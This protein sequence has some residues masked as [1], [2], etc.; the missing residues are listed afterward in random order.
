MALIKTNFSTSIWGSIDQHDNV[1]DLLKVIDEQFIIF[2]KSPTNTI[3]MYFSS[4][5][6]IGTKGVHDQSYT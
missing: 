6:L 5:K 3:I 4:L 1:R 2:D